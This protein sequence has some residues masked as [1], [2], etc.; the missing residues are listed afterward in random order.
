MG[1][2]I[3]KLLRQT[4]TQY[5]PDL[6]DLIGNY[7]RATGSVANPTLNAVT[8]SRVHSVPTGSDPVFTPE[9]PTPPDLAPIFNEMESR[10]DLPPG[11]LERMASVESKFNPSA[12]SPK[13]AVGI[14]QLMPDTA[15]RFGVTD[16]T[17]PRQSIEGGARYLRW[18]LDHFD[19]DIA[20]A[21]AAYNAGEGAVEQY[22]GI[23]PFPET[24]DYV[25]RVLGNQL[26][27]KRD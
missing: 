6:I 24:Q 25:R 22:N 4:A 16:R 10:Y 13:G 21:V 7:N 19:G 17:D 26:A 5:R 2:N 23:P 12:K 8:G 11:L 1:P 27:A 15:Q 14:M 3:A 18:L 20:R 9:R